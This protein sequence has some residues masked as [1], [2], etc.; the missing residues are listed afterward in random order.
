VL[1]RSGVGD[2]L[3][4]LLLKPAHG[5]INGTTVVVHGEGKQALMSAD[6]NQPAELVA[7][8]LGAG[9]AVLALDA[10]LTGEYH[11]P[12]GKTERN[13]EGRFP[14]TF[15]RTDSALRVQDVITAAQAAKALCPGLPINLVGVAEGGLWCLLAR[16]F[17]DEVAGTVV[18][19]AGFSGRQDEEFEERLFVPL[20]RRVGD[21]RTAGALCAPGRLLLHNAGPGFDPSWPQAAYQAAAATGNLTVRKGRASTADIIQ[22]LEAA[23]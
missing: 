12:G 19:L 10:F 13:L 4:A 17:L 8:L 6:L 18:D 23:P 11:P 21:L 1:G 3:P 20:L 9:Q 5:A 22:W 15:Y 7:A 2:A 16:P 14:W